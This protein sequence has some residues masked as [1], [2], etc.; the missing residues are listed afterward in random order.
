MRLMY[1]HAYQSYIWNMVASERVKLHGLKPI[2]GDLVY[3]KTKIGKHYCNIIKLDDNNINLY[4]I[5]DV[6]L[7]LPGHN[8]VYPNNESN[9]NKFFHFCKFLNFITTKSG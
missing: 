5:D 4:E 8:V 2:I 3:D 7:P 6:V 1:I 9:L